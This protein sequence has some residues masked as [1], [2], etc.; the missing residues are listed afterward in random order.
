[1]DLP[2]LFVFYFLFFLLF[3]RCLLPSMD[4]N[5]DA[6]FVGTITGLKGCK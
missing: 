5:T 6:H 2:L 4:G 1:M 3:F